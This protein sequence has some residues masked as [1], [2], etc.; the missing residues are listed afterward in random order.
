[1]R[2]GWIAALGAG[3]FLCGC[4]SVV[5]GTTEQVT[6]DSDPSGAEMRSVIYYPCGG[7]CPV[8]DEA[9]GSA[10]AYSGSDVRTPEVPGPACITP[11]TAQ[12][13]RNEEL[14]V[15]FSKAGYEPQTVRLTTKASGGG[16]AGMAG[17][18]ILGGAVGLVVDAGTGA[19]LDHYPN[20]LKVLLKPL[21]KGGK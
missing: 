8:R 2:I 9:V 12:V 11:C 16:A 21:P 17:N 14:L 4:A 10:A 15:T 20:P 3:L 7:P 6:F 1:M 5:R 13:A 19:A 18:I